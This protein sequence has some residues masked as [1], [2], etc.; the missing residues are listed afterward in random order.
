MKS[1]TSLFNRTIFKKNITHY[2]PA[3]ALYLVYL[4]LAMPYFMWIML[5]DYDYYNEVDMVERGLYAING[6]VR[7]GMMVPVI[8]IV[9]T[10]MAMLVFSYLY[11]A[12]NANMIHALPVTRRELFITNYLSGLAFLLI[13]QILTFIVTALVAL[14]NNVTC[15]QYAF[16]G[17]LCAAGMTVFFYSMAVFVAMF[18]GQVLAVGAYSLIM[19]LLYVGCVNLVGMFQTMVSYGASGDISIGKSAVLSPLY[20][21]FTHTSVNAA[22]GMTGK[23]ESIEIIGSATIFGYTLVGIALMVA[24]YILYQRRH[25]ETAGD[26]VSIGIIKPIFRWGVAICGGFTMAMLFASATNQYKINKIYSL[27]IIGVLAFGILSFF[28]AEMLLEK[29]FRVFKKNRLIECGVMSALSVLVVVLFRFDAFGIE[30]YQPK[31][32]EIQKAFVYMDYVIEVDDEDVETVLEL[33]K[34]IIKNKNEYLDLAASTNTG[35]Y[36]TTFRYYLK[37]GSCYTR[38]YPVPTTDEYLSR[39]DSAAVWLLDYEKEPERLARSILGTNYRENIYFSA[40][41]N[42]HDEEDTYHTETFGADNA[43]RIAKALLLD[44]EEG[45]MDDVYRYAVQR[46]TYEEYSGIE[47][48]YVNSN[49]NPSVWSYYYDYFALVGDQAAGKSAREKAENNNVYFHLTPQCSNLLKV[50]EDLGITRDMLK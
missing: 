37:D 3:W 27:I 50:L 12:R 48:N 5:Q 47:L 1:K 30:R 8:F 33:Q 23:L 29:N 31:P 9:S 6:V 34:E 41:I 4:F 40:S 42:V 21:L 45:N 24:A 49:G 35:Y 17:M 13:P 46:D 10:I 16:Y 26:L 38:R 22:Y 18:T 43:E 28:L 7:A 14:V 36:Y 15:I 25:I 32:D 20:Y 2:W 19:N 39:E 11:T 44:I